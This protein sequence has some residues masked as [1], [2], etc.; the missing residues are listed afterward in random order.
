MKKL[1]FIILF[2]LSPTLIA[3]ERLQLVASVKPL[4]LVAHAIVA[5]LGEVDLLIPPGASPHH[6]ALKPS[7]IRVLQK[8][9]LVVWVGPDMELFLEKMLQRY[10]RPVLQLMKNDEDEH[11][12]HHEEEHEAHHEHEHQASHDEA[13]EDDADHHHHH[14][15]VDPH[16]WM[17]PIYMLEAAEHI[18]E[19][20]QQQFPEL[21]DKLEANYQA[22][23]RD[24]LL[25]D[26]QIKQQ[27]TPYQSNGF[28]VF[29]DA[30]SL[31]VEHYGLNQ[32]AYFTV[33]PAQTP[34]A[35]KLARIER[36]LKEPDVRCVFV[37]PQF[38]APIVERIVDDLPV[39][40]G[41]LDPLATDVSLA[42]GYVGY[43]NSL[44]N[45]IETCLQ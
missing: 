33:D 25:A 5:D 34:G 31:F 17:D 32:R 24:L 20:L 13:E 2:L 7:D 15:D 39:N 4:Q 41:R 37:E 22:F 26:K 38:K 40:L 9:D 11:E 23:K 12:V 19:M 18:K 28:V 1:A 21:S 36:I 16:V 30:F 8:A 45:S 10:D 44:A 29:H 3:Q 42:E 27:L 35:K 6:Y 43:L 14:G